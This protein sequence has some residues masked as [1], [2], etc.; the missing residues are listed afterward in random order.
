MVVACFVKVVRYLLCSKTGRFP[1]GTLKD[2]PELAWIVVG[3][4]SNGGRGLALIPL[5]KRPPGVLHR[6]TLLD[7]P[8]RED[9]SSHIP[10]DKAL[11][12]LFA[13]LNA[14]TPDPVDDP[15]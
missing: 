12:K 15:T 2:V 5:L 9:V 1:S 10:P 11:R 4:V 13:F 6:P 8:K 3:R 7:Q 14:F